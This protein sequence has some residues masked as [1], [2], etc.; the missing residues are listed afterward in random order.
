[1]KRPLLLAGLVAA[2]F[3]GLP[4]VPAQAQLGER[5]L[6]IFGNDPCPT[7]NGEEIV[8]CQRL[9]E[10]ERYRIP[11]ELRGLDDP[12]NATWSDRARS[13]EYVGAGGTQSCSPVGAGGGTGCFRQLVRKAREENRADGQAPAIPL[14][15]P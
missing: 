9:D 13:I 2:T 6:T 3:A 12:K 8:V 14:K 15:L 4:S 1:M 7:S 10:N 5:V 11:K